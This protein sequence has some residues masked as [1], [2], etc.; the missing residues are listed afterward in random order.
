[1]RCDFQVYSGDILYYGV[2]ELW[3]FEMDL[4]EGGRNSCSSQLKIQVI[5]AFVA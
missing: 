3:L 5:F 1:M 2:L 4:V